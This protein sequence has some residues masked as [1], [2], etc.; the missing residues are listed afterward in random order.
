MAALMTE[1]HAVKEED[2]PGQLHWS[3]WCNLRASLTNQERPRVLLPSTRLEVCVCVW[4]GLVISIRCTAD[5]GQIY[6]D[7]PRVKSLKYVMIIH[8]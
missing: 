7:I 2:T 8:P 6:E 3:H 1:L 5:C 4:W